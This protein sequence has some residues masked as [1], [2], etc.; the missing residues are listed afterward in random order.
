[1]WNLETLKYFKI[2]RLLLLLIE[3]FK[4]MNSSGLDYMKGV[5]NY[6]KTCSLFQEHGNLFIDLLN[7]LEICKLI[8][9]ILI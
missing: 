9:Y 6:L 7:M 2:F 5:S 4:S 8:V 3:V 1:M